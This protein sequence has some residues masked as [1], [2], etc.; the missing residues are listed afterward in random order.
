MKTLLKLT[1]WMWLVA[2]GA[3]AGPLPRAEVSAKAKWVLHLDAEQFR[4]S[5]V[6]QHYVENLLTDQVADVET[7]I[8]FDFAPFLDSV[9][10]ATVYGT[11][12]AKGE[13]NTAVLLLRGGVAEAQGLEE[14]LATHSGTGKRAKLR[15]IQIT[16]FLLFKL[17]KAFAALLING[18]VVMG[19]TQ[20]LV[21]DACEVITG[22][23]P[24][25][26][27]T[28]RF[29]DLASTNTPY[30]LA[31][32]ADGFTGEVPL[33]KNLK[34]FRQVEGVQL[35]IRESAS[36][37]SLEIMLKTGSAEV[38]TQIK[39]VADGLL[40]LAKTERADNKN[41][42]ALIGSAT[43]STT[44]ETVTGSF[45]FSNKRAI[46][47]IKRGGTTRAEAR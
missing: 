17:E 16:P 6:G 45:E 19:K 9:L 41:L 32:A 13:D 47:L 23:Q 25:V 39:T 11:D 18:T 3:W 12:F 8:G 29:A 40:L 43:V 37:L 4:E 33:P 7:K 22:K 10:S 35:M 1:G 20:K 27:A 24:N 42:Q 44:G 36:H 14:F 15:Q 21:E 46:S 2:V 38:A 28:A 31:V 26:T 34:I 30:I 5:K